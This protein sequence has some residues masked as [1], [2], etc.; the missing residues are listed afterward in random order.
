AI[1]S[2]RVKTGL[3]VVDSSAFCPKQRQTAA[4][5]KMS[6]R[7]NRLKTMPIL[8]L[9]LSG[10]GD[11]LSGVWPRIEQRSFSF[12]MNKRQCQSA[13]A[14]CFWPARSAKRQWVRCAKR[15]SRWSDL[16]PEEGSV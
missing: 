2:S 10:C 5:A 16:T 13:S 3:D 4:P 1:A 15:P 7:Q 14:R 6:E 8:V 9:L 12:N 11:F